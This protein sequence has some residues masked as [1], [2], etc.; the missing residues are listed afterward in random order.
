MPNTRKGHPASKRKT[1]R[2]FSGNRFTSSRS[3]KKATATA[4]PASALDSVESTTEFEISSS[5]LDASTL[6]LVHL[7]DNLGGDLSRSDEDGE[8]DSCADEIRRIVDISSLQDFIFEAAVCRSCKDGDL[9][10]AETERAG[11]ASRVTLT[12]SSCGQ[13]YSSFLAKKSGKFYESQRDE[14][15]MNR[16]LSWLAAA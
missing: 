11:L 1:K 15:E 2:V 8:L 6:K 4:P 5:D 7:T 13:M 10:L 16:N 3:G 12:C 14:T 9:L